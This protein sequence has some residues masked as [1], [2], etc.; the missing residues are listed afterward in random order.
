MCELINYTNI[1]YG[2][3]F[4]IGIVYAL[5]IAWLIVYFICRKKSNDATTIDT[6]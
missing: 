2:Y 1:I 4:S 5:L 3:G 6:N